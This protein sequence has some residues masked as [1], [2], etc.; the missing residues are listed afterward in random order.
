MSVSTDA[1]LFFGIE[2]GEDCQISLDDGEYWDDLGDKWEKRHI[3]RPTISGYSGPEWD[4]WRAK[5]KEFRTS[6]IG[7]YTGRHCSSDYPMYYVSLEAHRQSNPR[8]YVT[9]IDSS[10][11]TPTQEQLDALTQ[12]CEEH[13]IPWKTPGWK[14]VS[15]WG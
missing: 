1:I 9:E 10:K 2:F 5:Q 6:G 11:M 4:E 13:S 14:L 3:Q 15:Y 8:G 12:F 7:I